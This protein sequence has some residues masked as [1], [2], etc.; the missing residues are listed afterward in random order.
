MHT[1]EY[2]TTLREKRNFSSG[3]LRMGQDISGFSR[4][5]IIVSRILSLQYSEGIKFQ[6]IFNQP[7][8]QIA[9]SKFGRKQ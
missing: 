1:I 8:A 9:N 4:K 7:R 3:I 6:K 5:E 2:L